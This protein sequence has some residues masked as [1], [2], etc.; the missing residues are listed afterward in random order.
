MGVKSNFQVLL[1]PN[2]RAFR[3]TVIYVKSSIKY[4]ETGEWILLFIS[5]YRQ[6]VLDEQLRTRHYRNSPV[7]VT[8]KINCSYRTYAE[9]RHGV[10]F[11]TGPHNCLLARASD[12]TQK[13]KLLTMSTSST[14]YACPVPVPGYVDGRRCGGNSYL[15][16]WGGISQGRGIFFSD[17][18]LV[19]AHQFHSTIMVSC[20]FVDRG[21]PHRTSSNHVELCESKLASVSIRVLLRCWSEYY[22]YRWLWLFGLCEELTLLLGWSTAQV[23]ITRCS[24]MIIFMRCS[25][26]CRIWEQQKRKIPAQGCGEC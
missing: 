4:K 5:G 1:V 11:F 15:P 16:R 22:E 12:P 6:S 14:L 10:D 8:N 18:F 19:S 24:R 9:T 2:Y 17:P 7:E 20:R 13:K 23:R 21:S 3:I 26:L 25:M